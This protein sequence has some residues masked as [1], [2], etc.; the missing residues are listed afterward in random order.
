MIDMLVRLYDLPDSSE[1]YAKMEERDITIRR[2]RAFE[3]HTVGEFAQ[4]FSD[5]WKS[6][7]EVAITRQPCAC[8]IATADKKILG[9]ACYDTTMKGFFGPA[10]VSESARGQGIGKALLFRAL[11]ALWEE[12]YAYGIIGGVGPREFYEKACGAM[13]ITGSDPSIYDDLLP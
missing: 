5:K 10:G 12:G 7:V 3:R 6:E 9:F 13:E 8:F 4:S 11:E 1:L 2:A